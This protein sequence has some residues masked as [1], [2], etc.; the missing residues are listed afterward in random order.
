MTPESRS[1]IGGLCTADRS[2]RLGNM[3]GGASQVKAHPF[4]EGIDWDALYRREEDGPI[5]PQLRFVGDTR[6]FD[7]YDPET[8]EGPEYTADLFE[9]Y[10]DA[11]KDF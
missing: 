10:E 7:Q 5:I 2:S 6:Y 9:K 3:A 8:T 11:F 4:F 1:L